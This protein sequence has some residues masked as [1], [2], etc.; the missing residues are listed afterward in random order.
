MC[1]SDGIVTEFRWQRTNAP[2]A[3]SRTD[4]I[5][6]L[7]ADRGWA[8]NSNGHILH[9]QDGGVT[10]VRQFSANGVYLRC[11]GFADDQRGWVGT[12]AAPRRLF[13][14][15]NGGAT[16]TL[17][18]N[19]PPEAPPAICGLTVVNERIL[20]ASGT[21]FPNR[22][23]GV[24]KTTD[25]GGTWTGWNMSAHATL[26]VD[27]Y[28]KD[29]QHGWV[30]GGKA[31]V[32]SPTR[33]DVIPV[34]LFTED[35]GETWINQLA[36]QE[37]EFPKGEWGWKIQFLD[38]NIGFVS[39]ENLTDGAILKT[40]DGGRTWTRKPVEDAQQNAN[41]E[42]IGFVDQNLGWTGGWGDI[43]FRTGFTSETRDGGETWTNANHVGKFLNRFR[44]IREPELVGYAS[45]DTIYKYA[46][47]S[48]ET[49][50]PL[51]TAP[52]PRTD[53]VTTGLPVHI[54]VDVPPGASFLRVDIWDRFGEHLATPLDETTPDA[55][56]RD[57]TWSG[58]SEKRRRATG[59]LYIYRI[60]IGEAAES[61]TL[62]ISE[63]SL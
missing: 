2:V 22:P 25:G 12:L 62:L 15:T 33:D 47:S 56:V 24:I 23:A 44:F 63:Y 36:D 53:L 48:P 8:V 54:P 19:L 52:E 29:A 10:W 30:V 4:D 58:E 7:D 60:T 50:Q 21:N 38:E 61:R 32:P 13:R 46:A 49:V 14:T 31:D 3:S 34:V 17:V 55:G 6:F 39:L 35:G 20:Y 28:F 11:V 1:G 27:I 41:L 9:T 43:S 37:A 42:G 57:V 18:D 5:W 16:W 26:L 51:L 40:V 45:G 59:G